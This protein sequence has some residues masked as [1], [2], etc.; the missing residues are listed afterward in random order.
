MN[1]TVKQHPGQIRLASVSY[2]NARP[3]IYGLD[4]D[5]QIRLILDV[6]SKLIEHLRDGSADVALLPAIDYQ[7][8]PELRM[9]PAGGIGCDGA[10][11]TVRI[12]AKQPIETIRTLACDPDSHTSVALARIILAERHQVRPEFVDLSRASDRA[13]EAR[14]LIGD[15]VVCEE[16]KGFEYQYDLGSEWKQMTGLPFVFAVWTAL[17]G[18]DLGD[19]P[20]RLENAKRTGLQQV[21]ESINEFAI[22]RGWPA[23]LARQY[24]KS[25]LKFDIGDRQLRAIELFY[26]LA[27]QHKIIEQIQPVRIY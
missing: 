7:R 20:Q 1:A 23:D 3:L 22:P 12:F 8:M 2:L 10:T 9:V 4:K 5:P 21:D 13:D 24:L 19:L 26:Q 14:L 25:Y 15:K 18:V 11:L 17:A 6:P 16:P 27:H